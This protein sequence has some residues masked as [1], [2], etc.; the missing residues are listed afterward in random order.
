MQDPLRLLP[1]WNH[2]PSPCFVEQADAEKVVPTVVNWD[3]RHTIASAMV[4]SHA[5]ND[6]CSMGEDGIMGCKVWTTERFVWNSPG[7]MW[8]MLRKSIQA[9]SVPRPHVQSALVSWNQ[10]VLRSFLTA[11]REQMACCSMGPLL[12]FQFCVAIAACCRCD[13]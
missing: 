2:T 1:C 8:K 9:D 6:R 5:L 13:V 3:W 7:T 10:R 4:A 12:N 11:H